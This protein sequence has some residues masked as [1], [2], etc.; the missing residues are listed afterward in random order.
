MPI[1]AGIGI[2]ITIG[3]VGSW[4]CGSCLTN[5][6]KGQRRMSAYR[7]SGFGSLSFTLLGSPTYLA[8]RGTKTGSIGRE[9][10]QKRKRWHGARFG[11]KPDSVD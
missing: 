3:W 2:G 7:N 5:N 11:A 8:P 4:G 1:L 9:K 6:R 10:P